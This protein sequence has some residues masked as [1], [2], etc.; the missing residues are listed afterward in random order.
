MIEQLKTE[1]TTDPLGRGYAGMSDAEAA[2]SLN[3]IDRSVSVSSI[4]PE[5]VADA[6]VASEFIALVAAKKDNVR[7][8]LGLPTVRV[9]GNTRDILLDAFG[10]GT[11]TRTNLAALQTKTVS[12]AEELG[13]GIVE[14][15]H[16]RWARQ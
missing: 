2:D 4:A 16:V 7:M 3:A 14:E 5:D 8:V 1:I 15:K 12:R 6:L 13:L 9:Q 10:P 11:G